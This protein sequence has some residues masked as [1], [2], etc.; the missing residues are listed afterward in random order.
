M[1]ITVS[2]GG[3]RVVGNQKYKL[4][5]HVHVL[6][7]IKVSKGAKIRNRYNQVPHLRIPMGK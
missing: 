6:H 2:T 7:Q 3:S 4:S 1:V 5:K